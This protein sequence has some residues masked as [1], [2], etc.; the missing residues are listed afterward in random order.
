M[1]ADEEEFYDAQSEAFSPVSKN[2]S[3]PPSSAV[4]KVSKTTDSPEAIGKMTTAAVTTAMTSLSTSTSD[5]KQPITQPTGAAT[6]TK[7][8]PPPRYST[9]S[10][11]DEKRLAESQK[12]VKVVTPLKPALSTTSPVQRN[13]ITQPAI[14][15]TEA[16]LPEQVTDIPQK[17]RNESQRSLDREKKPHQL[18]MTTTTLNKSPPSRIHSPTDATPAINLER[19]ISIEFV[20]T[21]LE[22]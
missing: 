1:E 7:Q 14:K 9:N 17:V 2:A 16:S 8:S 20:F 10:G 18:V 6:T 15:Q 13:I 22:S 21:Y 5:L 4:D 11:E 12:E 19:A 3:S